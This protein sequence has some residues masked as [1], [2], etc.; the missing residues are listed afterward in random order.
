MTDGP[1]YTRAAWADHKVLLCAYCEV[2]TEA[3]PGAIAG[4]ESDYDDLLEALFDSA[5]R[6]ADTYL[7]N[8][9]EEINPT[10]TF[11]GV[12]AGN[13]ISI[14]LGKVDPGSGEQ[15]AERYLIA[16]GTTLSMA[17]E[18]SH[19][20]TAAI[21]KDEDALEFAVGATDS[22]TADNFCELV[23]SATL[24]GSYGTVGME[25]VLATNVNGTVTLTRRYGNVDDIVVTSGDS[26]RL[27]VRQMRTT[28]DIP[29]EVIQWLYQFVKRHFDNR[30]ALMQKNVSGRDVKMWVSMK[31]EESGMVDN[32]NLI[33][34]LRV[35]VGL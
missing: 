22:E 33:S 25:G 32:F 2:D 23:N 4:V 27:L 34:H 6:R 14:G 3:S 8:P 20:Y 17:G 19:T 15:I 30:D 26:T 9:F 7:N 28:V 1:V 24:G 16:S 11:D 31:A 21:A 5:K 35:P 29:Y 12:V 13:S 18:K 10:I